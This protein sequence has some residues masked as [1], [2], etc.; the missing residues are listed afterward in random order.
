MK[1]AQIKNKPLNIVLLI[2]KIIV[3]LLMIVPLVYFTCLSIV[4]RIEVPEQIKLHGEP[5]GHYGMAEFISALLITFINFC[6]FI[7][8]SIRN[9][10]LIM[11]YYLKI[12]VIKTRF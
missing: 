2:F 9:S 6:L 5:P 8:N 7:I 10:N 3:P 12:L 1:G 11:R 4:D